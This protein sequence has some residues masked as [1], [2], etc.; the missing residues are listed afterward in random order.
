[1]FN[2]MTMNFMPVVGGEKCTNCKRLTFTAK[3]CGKCKKINYCSKECQTAHWKTH[4]KECEVAKITQ[5]KCNYCSKHLGSRKVESTSCKCGGAKYCSQEC[6][7]Y[8]QPNHK[9]NCIHSE[10]N[11]LAFQNSESETELNYCS[12]CNSVL[13]WSEECQQCGKARYCNSEC[14]SKRKPEDEEE[15][16]RNQ[17]IAEQRKSSLNEENCSNCNRISESLKTC[18]RCLK[19]QY[20]D[21]S[22]QKKDWPKHKAVCQQTI[23]AAKKNVL[24][25]CS[26]CQKTSANLKKCT[27]CASVQYCNRSCQSKHWPQHKK[28][29]SETLKLINTSPDSSPVSAHY[30]PASASSI[31]ISTDSIPASDGSSAASS[32][33]TQR[34]TSSYCSVPCS[35]NSSCSSTA[36]ISSA[37]LRSGSVTST[38]S[39][40][41]SEAEHS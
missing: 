33:S 15:C 34:I 41:S 36:Y 12:C 23:I 7:K 14:L 37:D 10:P 19:V 9:Q 20:C 2:L 26:F 28:K 40:A 38:N 3:K 4:K 25:N 30:Y 22:C 11:K 35:T 39:S 17:A 21:S 6:L 8:D 5:P 13:L 16:Q 24:E 29:C 32:C 27:K 18:S 1:M 31:P